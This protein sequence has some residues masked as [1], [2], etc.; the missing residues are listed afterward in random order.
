MNTFI[1]SDEWG[2]IIE[3]TQSLDNELPGWTWVP[4]NTR[5]ET[6]Y[7]DSQGQVQA[8]TQEDLNQKSQSQ[9]PGYS[10]RAQTKS[11]HLNTSTEF[12]QWAWNSI[13][14]QRDQLLAESDWMEIR[15]LSPG[16]PP[17]SEAWTTYRQQ[18]RDITQ[19]VSPYA[20]IWP[21]KP[22]V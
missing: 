9:L 19:Q 4:V 11:W 20:I 14:Y 17:V 5:L 21:T 2:N 16:Q 3:L 10:W 12:T 13:R 1:K 22:S 15:A 18:L 6:H 8:Y 7:I